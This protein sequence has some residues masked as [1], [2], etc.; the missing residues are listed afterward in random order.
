MYY[1]R[2]FSYILSGPCFSMSLPIFT[3]FICGLYFIQ[4]IAGGGVICVHFLFFS[5]T[6]SSSLL[7]LLFFDGMNLM[8]RKSWELWEIYRWDIWE[9]WLWVEKK[10]GQSHHTLTLPW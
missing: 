5:S 7:L 1:V 8:E 6:P 2:L 4:V 3:P 9:K 10:G